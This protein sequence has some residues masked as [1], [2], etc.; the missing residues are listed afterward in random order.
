MF[1]E[2]NFISWLSAPAYSRKRPAPK[3]HWSEN[4]QPITSSLGDMIITPVTTPLDRS[5][6]MRKE[7]EGLRLFCVFVWGVF[8]YVTDTIQYLMVVCNYTVLKNN[9]QSTPF[10]SFLQ[11]F[12]LT[13]PG[14]C[15]IHGW[16]GQCIW[17]LWV[18]CESG[19]NSPVRISKS[20]I[21]IVHLF[22]VFLLCAVPVEINVLR[23][24]QLKCNQYLKL[25][26]VTNF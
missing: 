7:G 18:G 26:V 8:Q 21:F 4:L 3:N 2:N 13:Y 6:V 10:N 11:F 9:Y 23:S 16:L 1:C 14:R 20:I 24:S 15:F 22:L 5:P 19:Q 17:W 12:S 25:D